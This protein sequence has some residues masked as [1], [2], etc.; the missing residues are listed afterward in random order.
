MN[1]YAQF[2]IAEFKWTVGYDLIVVIL[3]IALSLLIH[4]LADN[5]FADTVLP[6][7]LK[8]QALYIFNA[9]QGL[10]RRQLCSAEHFC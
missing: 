4:N 5:V 7:K 9:R 6:S 1:F 3:W 10:A 8:G 2:I